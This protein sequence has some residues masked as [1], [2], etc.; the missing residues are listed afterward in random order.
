MGTIEPL[1]KNKRICE[2]CHATYIINGDPSNYWCQ[3]QNL[4]EKGVLLI[5]G[6]CEFHRP[7]GK[8]SLKKL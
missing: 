1:P 4:P 5:E 6:L 7:I 3:L 2:Q 8:Y